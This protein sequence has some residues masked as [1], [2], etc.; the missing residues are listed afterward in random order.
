MADYKKSTS[1]NK[2]ADSDALFEKYAR[3]RDVEIRNEIVKSICT[4][5]KSY[6]ANF[7]PGRGF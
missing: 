6:P 5:L 4:W 7:E 2:P 3:E 1:L